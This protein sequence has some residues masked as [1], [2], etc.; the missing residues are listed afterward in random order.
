MSQR[1]HIGITTDEFYDCVLTGKDG[2]KEKLESEWLA[3]G[4]GFYL[5]P[6]KIRIG[7]VALFKEL[8]PIIAEVLSAQRKQYPDDVWFFYHGDRKI[9]HPTRAELDAWIWP[10]AKLCGLRGDEKGT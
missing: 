6:W 9:Q 1:L 3:I 4:H 8:E 2:A 5:S 7:D 10:N